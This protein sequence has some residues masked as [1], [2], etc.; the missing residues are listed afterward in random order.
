MKRREFLKAAGAAGVGSA[1]AGTS[2]ASDKPDASEP[3][4]PHKERQD[5]KVPRRKLGRTGVDVP[6]LALGA[7]F[8]FVDRQVVLRKCLEFGVNY[9]DSSS[10]YAGGN[11]E[12]GIGK[13]IKANPDARKDL[14]LV[15][16]AQ[17]AHSVAEIEKHLEA[18]LK[19]LNV[20]GID[21]YCLHS[22]EQP[23]QLTDELR[24][25]SKDAKARRLIRFFGVSTHK[26]MSQ[27]LTAVASCGWVDVAM[28]LYNFRFLR[29]EETALAIDACR[30][31]GVGLLAMKTQALLSDADWIEK[32]RDANAT[33]Q[34]ELVEHFKQRG[35]TEG[36]AKIAVVVENEQFDSVCVGMD[37][38]AVLEANT[39]VASGAVKLSR[40]D[41]AALQEYAAATCRGYC[42]G[43]AGICETAADAPICD[44]MRYLMYRNGYGDEQRARRLFAQLPAG[45]KAR[46]LTIDYTAAELRCR[47][48]MPLGN[49]IAQAVNKLA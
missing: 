32:P 6:C 27:C 46:L 22:L 36:Q 31:A 2:F 40:A 1:L 30:K 10:G 41:R 21:L 5:A 17:G 15:S 4:T 34:K 8:D 9:W 29:D 13:F 44:I 20:D 37:N 14:F 16:K 11:S 7:D 12:L 45:V 18:S 28:T 26:N 3:N 24:N 42:A 47:Q 35:F 23:G 38:V 19:R 39:A 25:W 49:L 33:A 43:C 48:R